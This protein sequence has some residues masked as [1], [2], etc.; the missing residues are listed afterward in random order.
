MVE[1]S[2][3]VIKPD[4]NQLTTALLVVFSNFLPKPK[5]LPFRCGIFLIARPMAHRKNPS[6]PGNKNGLLS[7]KN[8]G[9]SL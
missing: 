6:C 3:V 1:A 7:T 8:V 9:S 2:F 4:K 5:H